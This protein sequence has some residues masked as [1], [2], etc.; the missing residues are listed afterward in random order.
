MRL[1]TYSACP[2]S[3]GLCGAVAQL[4]ERRVRNAKV[5]VQLPSAPPNIPDNYLFSYNCRFSLVRVKRYYGVFH[6]KK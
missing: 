5:G 1:S 4:G 2:A 3:A 6:R